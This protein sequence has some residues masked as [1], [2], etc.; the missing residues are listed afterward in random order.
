MMTESQLFFIKTI[1]IMPLMSRCKIAWYS[2]IYTQ[3]VVDNI[4]GVLNEDGSQ[5]T[6][7]LT[8]ENKRILK[9]ASKEDHIEL[10][11]FYFEVNQDNI[12]LFVAYDAFEIGLISPL[13]KL[14]DGY[15][16]EFIIDAQ[17]CSITNIDS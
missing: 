8:E 3:K 6:F 1:G 13:V 16:K 9:R 12:K 17:V 10:H 11:I 14:P 5:F 4:D 15:V 2:N 7:F